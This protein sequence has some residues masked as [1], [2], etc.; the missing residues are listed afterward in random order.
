ML[1]LYL[2]IKILKL[3]TFIV[4]SGEETL[5]STALLNECTFLLTDFFLSWESLTNIFGIFIC[6]LKDL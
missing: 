5:S 3:K 2:N 4:L 6:D 1:Y